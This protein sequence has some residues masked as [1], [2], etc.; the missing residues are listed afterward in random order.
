MALPPLPFRIC[1]QVIPGAQYDIHLTNIKLSL[2]GRPCLSCE[3]GSR[4][5]R[6]WVAALKR[7]YILERKIPC[8][9]GTWVQCK[10]CTTSR[11]L[12]VQKKKSFGHSKDVPPRSFSMSLGFAWQEF[13]AGRCTKAIMCWQHKHRWVLLQIF[14]FTL[15][16]IWSLKMLRDEKELKAAFSM[17]HEKSKDNL[18]Q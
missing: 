6:D 10:R 8:I 15:T 18:L 4:A 3:K 13:H 11:T 2:C 14:A 1:S 12:G 17:I 7:T 16:Q 5:Y 9:Q